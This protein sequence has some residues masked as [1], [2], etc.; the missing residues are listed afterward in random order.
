[1]IQV[2]VLYLPVGMYNCMLSPLWF[3]GDQKK[4]EVPW[5]F[6]WNSGQSDGMYGAGS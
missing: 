6:K 1:M 3:F 2:G 4:S 5:H